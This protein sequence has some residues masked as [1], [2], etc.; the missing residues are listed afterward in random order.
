MPQVAGIL[1]QIEA[2][3]S[4]EFSQDVFQHLEDFPDPNLEITKDVFL[5]M[6]NKSLVW[7]GG[8]EEADE[9]GQQAG[10]LSTQDI[11]TD[12]AQPESSNHQVVSDS[13]RF[14]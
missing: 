6:M 7:Q 1:H 3:F 14:T 10:V 4:V 13:L 9:G 11:T 2:H 5:D 8:E 12:A